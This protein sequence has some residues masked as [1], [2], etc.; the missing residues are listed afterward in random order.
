MKNYIKV[1]TVLYKKCIKKSCIFQTKQ[2]K[3]AGLIKCY[4]KMKKKNTHTHKVIKF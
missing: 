3:I 2:Q 1:R 4:K